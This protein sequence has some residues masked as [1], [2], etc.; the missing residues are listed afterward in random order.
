[1]AHLRVLVHP[2]HGLNAGNRAPAL[3]SQ[4]GAV[5]AQCPRH[6]LSNGD[7]QQDNKEQ[8]HMKKLALALALGW[9]GIAS[10]QSI[11]G[12]PHDLGSGAGAIVN[13]GTDAGNGNAQGQV[14]VY[15]HFPHNAAFV[16]APLWNRKA[17]T[18][19]F[20]MYTSTN[21]QYFV[22]NP[23]EDISARPLGTVSAA[24][25]SCHD[26]VTAFN[27][28]NQTPMYDADKAR[29]GATASTNAYTF[30]VVGGGAAATMSDVAT[31]G[32]ALSANIGT[33]LTNDHPISFTYDAALVTAKAGLNPTTTVITGKTGVII[34][35]AGTQ[36]I[37]TQMLFSSKLEC[38]SCHEP[39]QH[40]D[41]GTPG[42]NFP[43]LVMSNQGS[44]LCLTCH[45][46]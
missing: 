8:S 16:G 6:R 44:Q 1:M 25:L 14:C 35:T 12:S 29:G 46:K 15:C 21:D 24:C 17:P 4:I 18:S 19:A 5:I 3:A 32:T 38:A 27:S 11:I 10:A 23:G 7:P 36:D 37:A 42:S 33:D 9:A 30:A 26:G 43:F 22:A 39:H 40:G 13:N 31:T 34:R 28:L 20:T 2:T 45:A 41:S